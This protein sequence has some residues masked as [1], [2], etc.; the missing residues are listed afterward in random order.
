MSI[1]ALGSGFHAGGSRR[2]KEKEIERG[3]TRV[4]LGLVGFGQRFVEILFHGLVAI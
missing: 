1:S 3:Q 4:G 2:A